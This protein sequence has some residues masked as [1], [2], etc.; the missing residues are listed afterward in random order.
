M[1]RLP[2]LK[3]QLTILL[4]S[5]FTLAVIAQKN[6]PQN[7]FISPMDI[8]L[9]LSGTFGELRTDHFHSGIDIRTGEV[10][11]LKVYAVAEG[12]V[13]RIKVSAGG[14]G[15]AIYITHPNGYVSVY[16]HLQQYGNDIN[17]YV[18]NEQCRRES[19][20]V[21]LYP[22]AGTLEVKQ[23][24]LIAL[25]G[26]SGGSG[27]PH[28]HFEIRDARTEKPI[29]PL[30]FGFIV[31][32]V[33]P[34]VINTLKAYPADRN[35]L[36]RNKNR[37]AEFAV[38]GSNGKYFLAGPD[39][40]SISGKAYFGINT[41]DLF[42]NGNNKNGVYSISLMLDLNLVFEQVM[43]TFS[44][45]ETRYIN[46]LIDYPEYITLQRRVQKSYIQP[47]NRLSV[48]K[49]VKNEGIINFTDDGVHLLT[50]KVADIAGNVS[51]LS[52]WVKSEEQKKTFDQ[53]TL[54]QESEGVFFTYK[55]DN[56]CETNHIKFEV[57]GSALYDTLLFTY[58][59]LPPVKNSFSGVHQLHKP[60]IP[61]HSRCSLSI[62]PDSLPI[63]LRDKAI[64]V[65]IEEQKLSSA[66]GE[67]DNGFISTQIREFGRYCVMV[68]TLAPKII[69]VNVSNNKN[70]AAQN[71]IKIQITDELSGISSYRGR[72]NGKWILMDY[73]PKNDL[74]TYLYDESLQ[75]G[76][77]IFELMVTDKK[78]NVS[79]YK[80]K[81]IY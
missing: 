22:A 40:V 79:N 5:I 55:K 27:G 74:L 64:I 56:V 63:A 73:D 37:E 45:D 61:V 57:P 72:L 25:S 12:Y 53:S 10:E 42:N 77:N 30:L 59:L 78:N 11:G 1:I 46:S 39:T 17:K 38:Q 23:G 16:A 9:H 35:C 51:I 66:G 43:E 50:Y 68:D 65:K 71:T 54:V 7:Y 36:I 58:K 60:T 2:F 34:P 31:A 69:P 4:F 70:I 14:Y 80:A 33:T 8:P 44:F 41:I 67:W 28:L 32:D 19:F 52:F 3:I 13:S 20:E 81:L 21:D 26:N 18:K 49:N 47:N 75:K 29:N 24:E 76:E 6:Y 62:M 48:Y 15:K